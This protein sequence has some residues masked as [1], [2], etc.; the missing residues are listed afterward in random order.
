MI[1]LSNSPLTWS[2][3]AKTVKEQWNISLKEDYLAAM[4]LCAQKLKLLA[5][6]IAK[7]NI[8][9]VIRNL[10]FIM[11]MHQIMETWNFEIPKEIDH[12]N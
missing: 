3:L 1:T 5:I 8:S 4:F 9:I 7:T 11:L 12:K 10:E 2:E 6:Q